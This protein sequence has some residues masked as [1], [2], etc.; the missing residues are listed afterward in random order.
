MLAVYM[1]KLKLYDGLSKLKE[2]LKIY[3]V[4]SNASVF[5]AK[6]LFDATKDEEYVKL[7]IE[8]A[9]K[10]GDDSLRATSLNALAQNN[11][12]RR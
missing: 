6:I 9:E 11:T 2:N 5:V 8:N 7:L 4:P 3:T 10:S 12:I 1:P